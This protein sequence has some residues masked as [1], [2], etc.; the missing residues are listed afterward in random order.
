MKTKISVSVNRQPSN[1]INGSIIVLRQKPLHS[2][3][4]G[5]SIHERSSFAVSIQQ[6]QKELKTKD[7][8]IEALEKLLY[9]SPSDPNPNPKASPQM[10][11]GDI[12]F[13]DYSTAAGVHSDVGEIGAD[14][15]RPLHTSD[16]NP[17]PNPNPSPKPKHQGQRGN[18]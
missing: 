8:K 5:D 10:H 18:T 15:H 7:K 6:Y 4:V 12:A 9:N 14:D 2:G 13:E 16:P 11:F 17:N 1:A 3:P